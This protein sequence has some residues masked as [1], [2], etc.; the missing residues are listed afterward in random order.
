MNAAVE[1]VNGHADA[2]EPRFDP[3]ALAEAAAIRARAD[4]ETEARLALARAEAKAIETRAV[5]DAEKQRIANERAA[6]RFERE[7]AE[8]LAKI[9]ESNRKRGE[10]E[11]L[12]AE[13]D[14]KAEAEQQA[15]TE[16]AKEI[17]AADDSW[18]RWAIRFAVVCAVVA[19]PVQMSAFWNENA[20]W[21]VAA[22]VMLEGGAW[23][24]HRGARAA[25]VSKR[26]VWHY[27][28]ITWLLAFVA[29]AVNLYHGLHAFDAGTAI[30]TA[31]A[32]I[33][34][35]G[36]WDLHEHGRI[37]RRDGVLTRRERKERERAERRA[38]AEKAAAE[39]RA[40]TEREAK[41]KAA[42]EAAQQ[43]AADREK[44]FPKVWEHAL[45]LAA[46]D[47]E[48][49]P[50]ERTWRRAHLDIEGTEPGDSVD[51]IRGRN[52]AARRVAAARSEAPGSTPSKVTTAQRAIQ[53]KAPRRQSTYR[54]TPPRR[55]RGDT[56]KFHP[57]AR[58][59]AADARRAANESG[60]Q[61]EGQA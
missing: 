40:A 16:A 9:A 19:L 60:A 38:A 4:A 42:A 37:R 27:R 11:R 50:S 43:L 17:E 48:T 31:L 46:A 52:I 39:Q 21:M 49:T 35:P 47:G 13:A 12:S 10:T 29:A 1:K 20:A 51:V 55:Q 61:E 2:A 41:E 44:Y 25:S 32:S 53:V 22:P 3:V 14:A 7:K 30:G 34:G 5:E 8:Q 26:P 33:A 59:L 24:V 28:A 23:V 54:P 18:R 58:A 6:L 57:A 45:R 36:V 56:P 15:E